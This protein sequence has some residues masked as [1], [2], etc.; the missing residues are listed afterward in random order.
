MC[1]RDR[2]KTGIVGAFCKTYNI[3]Q[4]IAVFLDDVYT[5]CVNGRYTYTEGSTVGGAVL[6]QDGNFLYSNHATDPCS[7]KLVNSFDLVRIHKFGELDYDAAPGTPT[8]SLPSYKQMIEFAT[9]DPDVTTLLLSL[10]HI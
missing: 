3:E 8:V 9:S 5:P 2:Q 6:Y 1:I 4:A 7:G 10:I